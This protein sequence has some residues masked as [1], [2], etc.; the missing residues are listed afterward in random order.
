M[1]SIELRYLNIGKWYRRK[2]TPDIGFVT[3]EEEEN[4]LGLVGQ[5]HS[6]LQDPV[7]RLHTPVKVDKMEDIINALDANKYVMDEEANHKIRESLQIGQQ[8]MVV[9]NQSP[10]PLTSQPPRDSKT[11]VDQQKVAYTIIFDRRQSRE[12]K[13]RE[14]KTINVQLILAV[15]VAVLA[16]AVSIPIVM[17]LINNR[18]QVI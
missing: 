11:L 18:G 15:A 13:R 14:D 4:D 1:N 3:V 2:A 12:K 6:L 5:W 16:V 7:F 10:W 17:W 8:V 9:D